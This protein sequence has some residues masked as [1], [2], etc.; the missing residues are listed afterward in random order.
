[1]QTNKFG[2]PRICLCVFYLSTTA[3]PHVARL[4]FGFRFR[5][6]RHSRL[7]LGLLEV[8]LQ[9]LLEV[10]V[11]HLILVRNAE[12]L[13]QRRV[14][15]DAAL[16]RRVE[17][18]VLLDVRRDVL[19]HLRLRALLAGLELHERA[20]LIRQ[21][22][23]DEERIVGAA[24]LPGL[25]LLRGHVL[26]A[27]ALLLLGVTGLALG[28]LE[29]ILHALDRLAD[30]GVELDAERLELLGERGEESLAALRRLNSRG[31]RGLDRRDHNLGLGGR[32][33][34][35]GLLLLDRGSLRGG[36]GGGGGGDR[37]GSLG[38]LLRGH[39]V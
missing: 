6:W 8:D 29:R 15:Q 2:S 25:A 21:R 33:G 26:R 11:R 7:H 1:M 28:G 37:G 34:L 16:E 4:R 14:R 20:E 19:G 17:A 3:A 35:R 23:L 13:G 24:S 31:R 5:F 30:L 10:Q 22:A 12:Q 32:G 38:I 39:L 9:E 27:L 18:V 36:R